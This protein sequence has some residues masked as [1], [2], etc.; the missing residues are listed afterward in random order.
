MRRSRVSS[1]GLTVWWRTILAGVWFLVGCGAGERLRAE[2]DFEVGNRLFKEG[3]FEEAE[4]SYNRELAASGD[5]AALRHNLGKAREALGDPGGAILEWERAVRLESGHR[6][7]LEAAGAVRRSLGVVGA[8]Q[9]WWGV[10]PALVRGRE[11]WVVALGG[12]GLVAAGLGA[13]LAGWRGRAWIVGAASVGVI[14]AGLFFAKASAWALEEAVI[15]ERVISARKAP[16]DPAPSLGEFPA[17][18]VVRI[19]G[20]SAGWSRCRL[21]DGSVGWLPSRAV[22]R[23]S[24]GP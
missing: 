2:T 23:I 10:T 16:A 11:L 9:S 7:S 24:S 8:R 12:W 17:G 5:S 19:L 15:R 1:V 14:A 4:R 3:K 20:S 18:T 22:E 13:G 21:P 6:L